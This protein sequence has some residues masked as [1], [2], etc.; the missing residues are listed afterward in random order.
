M[1]NSFHIGMKHV[2]PYSYPYYCSNALKT[3]E[4]SL[5]SNVYY[6]SYIDKKTHPTSE[7]VLIPIGAFLMPYM[8]SPLAL[9]GK[10]QCV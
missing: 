10:A 9:S 7:C 4:N 3:A 5:K 6:I 1:L 2:Y 8:E